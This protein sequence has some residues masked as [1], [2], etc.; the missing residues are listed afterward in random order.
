M[1]TS[2]MPVSVTWKVR[3]P[4]FVL[5]FLA[6][7]PADRT[8]AQ[9]TTIAPDAFL[10]PTAGT[11]FRAA[12]G[13]WQSIDSSVVRYTSVIKQR[14]AAGIRTPLKDRT[15][16]R[17]ESAVRAFWD[18]DNGSILQ[19]MGSRAQYPGRERAQAEDGWFWMDDLA[20]DEPFE[21]GGCPETNRRGCPGRLRC[22]RAGRAR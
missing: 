5:L 14:I 4:T 15:L 6:L 20:M 18:R 2:P 8:R 3:A 1:K 17:N 7:G 19:V 11:L 16:Y 22:R 13:N 21:P 9:Q 12:Q 10:D